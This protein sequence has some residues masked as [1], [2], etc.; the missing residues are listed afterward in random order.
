MQIKA[1][2]AN[3][4]M[5]DTWAKRGI[6][7]SDAGVQERLSKIGS[8]VLQGYHVAIASE[9]LEAIA[10]KMNEI[11]EELR[12]FGYE[13]VG[14][15]LAQRDLL[16]PS[17]ENRMATFVAGDGAAY[18]NWVYVGLGLMLARARL[19]IKPHLEKLN[20]G[21]SWLAIDGYGYY[22]GMFHW[23]DSLDNQVISEQISGYARSVFDQGLGRSI[24]FIG[25]GDVNHIAR[26]IDTF[27]PNRREDL[28]G[29]VGYA[30]AYAGGAERATIEALT[31]TAGVYRFQLTQ[32][33]AYAAKS[34]QSLGNHS[35]YTELAC[36]VLWG[37]GADAVANSLATNGEP[38]ESQTWQH[39][40]A[41][42][43][44]PVITTI[45]S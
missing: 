20:F 7:K 38:P 8:T 9:D 29:G 13:G 32:G 22:Q 24:W 16:T 12:G 31:N 1:N 27:A 30:C 42:V 23:Q 17:S 28:W 5:A 41:R 21:K 44:H 40:R 4:L 10:P 11:D 2:Q 39:Y 3:T 18:H 37:M 25:G 26:T 34:R 33:T 45:V 15:G 43:F 14:M 6:Q 36:Q 35:V 19:P